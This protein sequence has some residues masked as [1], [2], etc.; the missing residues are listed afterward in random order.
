MPNQGLAVQTP[1]TRTSASG[2][3]GGGGGGQ[4]VARLVGLDGGNAVV[5]FSG[6]TVGW[7][8]PVILDYYSSTSMPVGGNGVPTS[9]SG[10]T[11]PCLRMAVAAA[12]LYLKVEVDSASE[13]LNAASILRTTGALPTNTRTEGYKLLATITVAGDGS[14]V[15]TP[16]VS[17]SF[18]YV[19]GA[20]SLHLFL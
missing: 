18:E 14:P 9:I 2:G 10:G 4:L 1:V 8:I 6:G 15:V 13:R 16:E 11:N 17:R 7:K 12:L 20:G 5:C 19:K 3:V